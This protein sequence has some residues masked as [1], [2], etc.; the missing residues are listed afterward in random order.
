MLEMVKIF[1]IAMLPIFE[2]RGAIPVGVAMG[3]DIYKTFLLAVL[4]NMLPVPFI[5]LLFRKILQFLQTKPR[6]K[7]LAEKYE[8]KLR[9]KSQKVQTL[10]LIG[11]AIF[12]AI[13]LPGTG[14]WTGAFIA[15]ILE[16]RLKHSIFSI[17]LGVLTAGVIVS[18]ATIGVI[19]FLGS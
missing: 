19:H 10:G 15:S 5:I 3:V 18:A 13:P 12:V 11:L 9:L 16:M 2:L 1:F 14:A 4:G 7:R 8:E 17:L 6:F